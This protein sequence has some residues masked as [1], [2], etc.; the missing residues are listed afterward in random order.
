MNPRQ[1][2]AGALV[3]MGEGDMAGAEAEFFEARDA[4]IQI[5]PGGPREAEVHSYL[6][7]FYTQQGQLEKASIHEEAAEHIF[8]KYGEMT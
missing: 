6:A 8:K 1:H 7:L 4:A 2:L 3:K 5:D